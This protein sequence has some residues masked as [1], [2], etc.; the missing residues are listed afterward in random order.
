MK[1]K[2]YTILSLTLLGFTS[3]N[4]QSVGVKNS[5]EDTS[6][7][8]PAN[9]ASLDTYFTQRGIQMPQY[10]LQE[11][12]NPSSPV[13][14]TNDIKNNKIVD[15]TMIFNYNEGKYS[16]GYYVWHKDSWHI[17]FYKG[18]EPQIGTF[19]IPQG[20]DLIAKGTGTTITPIKGLQT[21]NNS[22]DK[23]KVNEEK[24]SILLPAGKYSYKYTVDGLGKE[25]ENGDYFGSFDA[26]AISTFLRK[27]DGTAL[28]ETTH[29]TSLGRANGDRKFVF[30]QGLFIFELDEPTEIQQT[31]QYSDASSNSSGI[32][33]RTN[34]NVSITRM[35]K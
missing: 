25:D 22:I 7:D 33:T 20:Q 10:D 2:L 12:K 23:S 1:N 14:F 4:A 26:Y 3:L 29:H 11:L 30:F 18:T 8:F 17:A 21:K 5:E 34:Y 28:T 6:Y 9:N 32:I 35:A 24:N 31:F 16:K 19:I 15:G 13:N 27:A